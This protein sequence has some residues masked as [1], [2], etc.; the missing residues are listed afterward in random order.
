MAIFD[1]NN[2]SS[3]S[4]VELSVYRFVVN[5]PEKVAYMRVRD[6]AK[7]THVANSSVMRFVHKIGFASFPEFKA[8]L[9]N[10]NQTVTPQ[11]ALTFINQ[12]NFPN[13]IENKLRV[14]ADQLYLSD[15][16]PIIGTGNSTSTA[17]YAA[18]MLALLGFNAF[19][20]TDPFYP[21]N[22]QLENT[23]NN[24]IICFSVSGETTELIEQL[25]YCTKCSDNQVVAI[26]SNPTST[27]ANISKYVLNYQE[28]KQRLFKYCDLSSQIPAMY[29]VEGLVEIL[30]GK[31]Q[32]LIKQKQDQ[33]KEHE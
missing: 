12:Q 24:T 27:I 18:R 8:Y 3:L 5:N 14:V 15:N 23:S 2:L 21:L 19:S 17:V 29:I 20:I 32:D 4:D 7:K 30:I 33:E 16:I 13:D 10:I 1:F 26:T 6:I 28:H 25:N 9:K 11:K 22:R 31:N